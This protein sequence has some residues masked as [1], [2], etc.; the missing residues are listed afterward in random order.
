MLFAFIAIKISFLSSNAGRSLR[1]A[2]ETPDC[3][4]LPVTTL[5]HTLVIGRVY[6]T[7][8]N[9]PTGS[10]GVCSIDISSLGIQSQVEVICSACLLTEVRPF[11]KS[12]KN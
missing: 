9:E 8:I 11:L 10:G 3:T 12:I 4:S 5:P 6:G 1:S 7:A 2:L